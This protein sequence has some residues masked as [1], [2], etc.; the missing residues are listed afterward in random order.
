M[1]CSCG[2]TNAG[3]LLCFGNNLFSSLGSG[4][5]AVNQASPTPV[6]TALLG[7][8]ALTVG[9]LHSC[10]LA[11]DYS[12]YCWGLGAGGRLGTGRGEVQLTAATPIVQKPVAAWAKLSAGRDHTCGLARMSAALFC[13]G[14]NEFG[15]IGDGGALDTSRLA[16]TA[17]QAPAGVQAWLDVS[18]GMQVRLGVING[19][20]GN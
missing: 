6:Q 19:G 16:P 17:V 8:R 12:G 4:Q 18:A 2:L 13:F 11:A 7:W 10:A 14:N 5:P 20:K 9:D 3:T 1:F 15:Q